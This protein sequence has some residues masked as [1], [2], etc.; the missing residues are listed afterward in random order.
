MRKWDVERFRTA[1]NGLP[2]KMLLCGN[3]DCLDTRTHIWERM[4][5]A[6]DGRRD[7]C[8]ADGAAEQAQ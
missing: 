3:V 2:N 7:S 5:N 6:I 4:L 1:M 8:G